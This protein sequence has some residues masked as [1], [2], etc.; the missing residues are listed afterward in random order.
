MLWDTGSFPMNAVRLSGELQCPVVAGNHDW[1]V[2]GL[3][4]Y[5]NT[6]SKSAVDGV[7]FTKEIISPGNLDW[8]KSLPLL[9]QDQELQMVHASLHQPELWKYP[10]VGNPHNSC[11]Q[12]I[13]FSF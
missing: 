8:L 12:S 2:A 13:Q 10:I 1:A 7:E 9:Y 11:Y 3:T 5:E 4:D 6:F